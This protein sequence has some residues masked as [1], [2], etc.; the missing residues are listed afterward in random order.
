MY[1]YCYPQNSMIADVWLEPQP[2]S[3]TLTVS[4]PPTVHYIDKKLWENQGVLQLKQMGADAL[5]V[6]ANVAYCEWS[7]LI[8]ATQPIHTTWTEPWGGGG[9]CG[10]GE[11]CETSAKWANC[12]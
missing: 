11:E 8:R 7:A 10:G 1:A 6:F 9:E 5:V 3:H 2:P 12:K 4:G